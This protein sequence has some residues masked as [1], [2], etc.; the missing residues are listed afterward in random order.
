MNTIT[1]DQQFPAFNQSLPQHPHRYVTEIA[2]LEEYKA[3]MYFSY[4]SLDPAERKLYTEMTRTVGLVPFLFDTRARTM[5]GYCV[6]FRPS[7][8]HTS[9][10]VYVY[11]GTGTCVYF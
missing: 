2:K 5:Q 9:S 1:L 10:I 8:C 4:K 3:S 7:S 6:S 11:L